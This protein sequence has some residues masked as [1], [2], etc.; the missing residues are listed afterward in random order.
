MI[1][2]LGLPVKV[3]EEKRGQNDDEHDSLGVLMV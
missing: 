2:R 3:L 1:P